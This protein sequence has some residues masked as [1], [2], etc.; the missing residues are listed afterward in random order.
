MNE[1]IQR[2]VEH[3]PPPTWT[4]TRGT[5]RL[6]ISREDVDD[7]AM[8]I[9]AG[10]G[11]PRSYF[12]REPSRLEV[13]QHDMETLLLKTGWAFVDFQPDKRGVRDRRG[14]PRKSDDRRRWWTDGTKLP[15]QPKPKSDGAA[16]RSMP[17][18]PRADSTN[19]GSK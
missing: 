15:R 12:F 17:V 16:A 1:P 2:L 5:D 14:W 8:L 3:L 4:F 9:V 6:E 18:R 10:D 19:T 11:A 7:G 13:F